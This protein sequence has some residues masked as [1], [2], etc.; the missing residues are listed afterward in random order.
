LLTDLAVT[1]EFHGYPG[2]QLMAALK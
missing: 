1:Q 2:L